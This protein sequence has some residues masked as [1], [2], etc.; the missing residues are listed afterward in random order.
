ML[1]GTHLMHNKS[2]NLQSLSCKSTVTTWYGSLYSYYIQFLK[3]YSKTGKRP[4]GQMLVVDDFYSPPT[5]CIVDR[6]LN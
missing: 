6:I 4:F 1:K 5:S 3:T 2:I